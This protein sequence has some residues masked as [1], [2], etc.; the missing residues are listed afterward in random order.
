LSRNPRSMLT[1]M[2]PRLRGAVVLEQP[3]RPLNQPR[4]FTGA[5]GAPG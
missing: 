4:A 2:P 5:K 3:A 1:A